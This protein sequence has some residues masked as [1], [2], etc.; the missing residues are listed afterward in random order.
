MGISYLLHV[1]AVGSTESQ[2]HPLFV[3][4]PAGRRRWAGNEEEGTHIIEVWVGS[5]LFAG[6]EDELRAAV[7]DG[8]VRTVDG[9]IQWW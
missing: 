8:K 4:Y 3:T 5:I 6:I 7:Q 9:V 1:H 2:E